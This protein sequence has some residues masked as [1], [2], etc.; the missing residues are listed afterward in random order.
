MVTKPERKTKLFT[1]FYRFSE[2]KLGAKES[3]EKLPR[4]PY[5]F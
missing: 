1:P 4:N 2:K 3:E 5:H